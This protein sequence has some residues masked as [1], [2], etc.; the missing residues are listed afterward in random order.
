[1]ERLLITAVML[2]MA[3]SVPLA[4]GGYTTEE[5]QEIT[6]GSR[7][8]DYIV[9]HEL[10]PEEQT[11]IDSWVFSGIIAIADRQL[12]GENVIFVAKDKSDKE[13]IKITYDE[14]TSKFSV[15]TADGEIVQMQLPDAQSTLSE[16]TLVVIQDERMTKKMKRLTLFTNGPD[17]HKIEAV[18]IER[19]AKS[20]KSEFT[21]VEFGAL[22][23]I[24]GTFA[25]LAIGTK[26]LDEIDATTC[27]GLLILLEEVKRENLF[28]YTD[29]HVANDGQ[30]D[31]DTTKLACRV[32]DGGR[33]GLTPD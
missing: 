25:D 31:I 21:A 30:H 6:V 32:D 15:K 13:R 23:N 7:S 3:N 2:M 9:V 33:I 10:S 8:D 26:A 29:E 27:S 18:S 19:R 22:K 12:E 4:Q 28:K 24:E 5:L 16:R 20:T 11:K 1:M 17:V 14:G